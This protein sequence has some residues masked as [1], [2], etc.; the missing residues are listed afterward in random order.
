M[1]EEANPRRDGSPVREP[2][3]DGG[4]AVGEERAS[5]EVASGAR[6]TSMGLVRGVIRTVRPHQWVKNLFVLAPLVFAKQLTDPRTIIGAIGAFGVFCLLAGSIYTLND[7]L[8]VEADRIHPVK[9]HRPIASGA[10]PTGVAKGLIA[11][12]LLVAFG[13]AALARPSSWRWP[14]ATSFSTPPIRCG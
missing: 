6:P 12:L 9:R 7:L 10:V 14:R 13:G 1:A 11:F 3:G 4:P 2:E 8:D 5:G